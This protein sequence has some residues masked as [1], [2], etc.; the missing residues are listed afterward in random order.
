MSKLRKFVKGMGS[1][2][3]LVP[4]TQRRGYFSRTYES[5]IAHPKKISIWE[6]IGQDWKRVGGD[7]WKAIDEVSHV[8]E[9]R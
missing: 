5:R 9:E 3:I 6:V 8:Q 2:I 4:N 1:P 7:M